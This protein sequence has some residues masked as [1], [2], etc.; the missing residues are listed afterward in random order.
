MRNL[1]PATILATGLA[2]AVLAACS[3]G[4]ADSAPAQASASAAQ[5]AP[6]PG[7]VVRHGDSFATMAQQY[8]PRAGPYAATGASAWVPAAPAP[9]FVAT[10]PMPP[11]ATPAPPPAAVANRQPGT[12]AP[13]APASEGVRPEAAAP[14]A[15]PAR[16]P[17]V[18]TAGLALF[19][20]HSCGTCHIFADACATGTVGPSLDRNLMVRTIVNVVT[21]GQGAMPSFRGAMSDAEI[22][23]LATY[24]QQYS[25]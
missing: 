12:P 21:N 4:P 1:V 11:A 3:T 22:A 19:T 16:D 9:A 25:R 6:A 7:G 14:A 23:A 8:T 2:A 20:T 15:T 10:G 17:A 18:R 13:A 24:I 5:A